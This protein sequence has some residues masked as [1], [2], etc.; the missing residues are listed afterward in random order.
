MGRS[1]KGSKYERQFSVMLSLWW[2]NGKNDDCFWRTAG[3]GG[4][5]RRRG[6]QK[7]THG[8][9]GDICATHPD[10]ESLT[11]L[12]TLELKCGYNRDTIANLLDQVPGAARQEYETWLGKTIEAASQA[13][14][15]SWLLVHHRDRRS[16][17]VFFPDE[18]FEALLSLGCFA[19]LPCP[20]STFCVKVDG[21][22][23][24]IHSMKLSS[25]FNQ[26]DPADI[27][28]LVKRGNSL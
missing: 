2:T 19:S 10:G 7:R 13:G 14:T 4:R 22:V 1:K 25:F 24:K 15:V 8:Q 20:F 21:K 17:I 6:A 28:R 18:L 27:K 9:H 11:K 23:I 3:S 26:V 5:A 16:N 12:L